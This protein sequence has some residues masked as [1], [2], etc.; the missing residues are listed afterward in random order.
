[1]DSALEHLFFPTRSATVSASVHFRPILPLFYNV[2]WRVDDHRSDYI[3]AVADMETAHWLHQH[4]IYFSRLRLN[5]S[6]LREDKSVD[7]HLLYELAYCGKEIKSL[8]IEDLGHY[9]EG[10]GNFLSS[11][12]AI[13]PQLEEFESDSP[14]GLTDMVELYKFAGSLDKLTCTVDAGKNNT[15]TQQFLDHLPKLT[16]LNLTIHIQPKPLPKFTGIYPNIL[17][18]SIIQKADQ[19]IDDDTLKLY[20]KAFPNLESLYLENGNYVARGPPTRTPIF[21]KLK[22]LKIGGIDTEDMA[23]F[24]FAFANIKALLGATCEFEEMIILLS[25]CDQIEELFLEDWGNID[26][27]A[28]ETVITIAGLSCK[29][30]KSLTLKGLAL[31]TFYEE[32]NSKIEKLTLLECQSSGLE[33]TSNWSSF[34]TAL[35]EVSITAG[36]IMADVLAD[37]AEGMVEGSS[38]SINDVDSIEIDEVKELRKDF[39]QVRF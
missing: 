2:T 37:I 35:K 28:Y 11:M 27:D 4:L 5:E 26:M 33:D 21:P 23:N 30:L 22:S 31:P 14:I 29:K 6:S 3:H 20:A 25:G 15:T 32:L 24:T 39:P 13:C 8:M 17:E 9:S 34:S 16:H 10:S 1:L 38:I 18:I 12:L 7:R 19:V 36:D